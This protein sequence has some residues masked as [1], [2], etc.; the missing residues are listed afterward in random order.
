METLWC[1]WGPETGNSVSGEQWLLVPVEEGAHIHSRLGAKAE[2]TL[3]QTV[4]T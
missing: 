4:F 3:S 1:E 2:G